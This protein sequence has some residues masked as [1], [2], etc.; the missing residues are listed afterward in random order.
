MNRIVRR[1]LYAV[2][3]AL[4]LGAA[5]VPNTPPASAATVLFREGFAGGLGSFS[6]S[7]RV[8]VGTY[9]VRLYGGLSDGAITSR[10][11]STAGYRNLT[12]T[13]T[14]VTV[15]LDAGEAAIA[16]ISIDGG[17]FEA[18]E[19]V[20][21]ASGTVT[22]S[23]GSR[24][25]NRQSVRLRFRV[26]ASSTTE[27]VTI[28]EIVL[29]GDPASGGG[30]GVLPP[31]ASVYTDGPFATTVEQGRGPNGAGWVV[32]P[33]TLGQNGLRHP[34]FIWGP[35]GGTGPAQYEFHLRRI[36]SHGFVVYSEPS[37]G[38]GSEMRAA[39]TW[40]VSENA[41][42]GSPYY[43]KLDVTRIAVGGHSQGSLS[44]FGAASDTRISTTIHVAGGSF[45]GSGPRSLRRPAAYFCGELDTLATRNCERDYQNT[46][47]PVFFTI[48]QDVDHISAARA[49]LPAIVAWLRWHIGGESFRSSMFITPGCEFCTGM[50]DSRWKNW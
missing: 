15:G 38:T 41:R 34:V 33:A 47:V 42:P 8:T 32:R 11:I 26:A 46:T 24:A 14:R 1:A 40:L 9:G 45:D 21:S 48:M 37:T 7:G 31:V 35:G 16:E 18:V 30:G 19:S 17:A 6:A 29:A 12:L 50:W 10:A 39:I 36:A 22:L 27:Y 49:A 20:R 3:F 23:L 5:V 43:G 13:Y 2:G 4:L 25:D 44:A 28:D